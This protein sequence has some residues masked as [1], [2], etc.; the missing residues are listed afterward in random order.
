MSILSE[1]ESYLREGHPSEGPLRVDPGWF[2]LWPLENIEQ[3]NAEY[4]VPRYAPGFTGFGSS[5]G[6]EMLAFDS[7]GFIYMIPFIGMDSCDAIKIADSWQQFVD[8]M[9]TD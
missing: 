3:W 2:Q 1:L 6:G 9:G 5:G 7:K 8:S 4:E